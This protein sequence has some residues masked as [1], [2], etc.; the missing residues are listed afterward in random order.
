M[1]TS[2]SCLTQI[3]ALSVGL[4]VSQGLAAER[5]AWVM[6]TNCQYVP[7]A[8]SDGDS[9]RV[10]GGTNEFLLSAIGTSPSADRPMPNYPV[11]NVGGRFVKPEVVAAPAVFLCS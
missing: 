2:P 10:R 1:A 11:A 6:L 8:D 3:M 5:K 7:H 9:F 4:V